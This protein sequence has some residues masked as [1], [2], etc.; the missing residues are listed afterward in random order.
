MLI[1]IISGRKICDGRCN[2]TFKTSFVVKNYIFIFL[3][4]RDKSELSETF[5]DIIHLILIN[6]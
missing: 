1:L 2:K 3:I 4:E 6:I 5:T